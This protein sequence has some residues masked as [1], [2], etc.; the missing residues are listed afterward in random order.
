M[1][2]KNW[3][4]IIRIISSEKNWHQTVSGHGD[5]TQIKKVIDGVAAKK[6]IPIHTDPKNEIYH[7]KWHNNV[8]S[9]NMHDMIHLK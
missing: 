6:I 5:G 4:C 9:V 2:M 1:M 7:K 3:L 8:Q